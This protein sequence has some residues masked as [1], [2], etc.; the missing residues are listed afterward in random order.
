MDVHVSTSHYPNAVPA[1]NIF[2]FA[3]HPIPQL[4]YYL[5]F[6]FQNVKI[7]AEHSQIFFISDNFHCICPIILSYSQ[8]DKLIHSYVVDSVRTL[9]TDKKRD[10][11]RNK[12]KLL[13]RFFFTDSSVLCILFSCPPLYGHFG[14]K[15]CKTE[16]KKVCPNR[17]CMIKPAKL[18]A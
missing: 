10:I 16:N 4:M 18:S 8:V 6:V 7:I 17:D 14:Q 5:F 12:K 13:S 1:V 3:F 9:L 15:S 11:A 2:F